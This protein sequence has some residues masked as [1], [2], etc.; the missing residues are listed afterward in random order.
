[1]RSRLMAGA[2]AL[3]S[4]VALLTGCGTTVGGTAVKAGSGWPSVGCSSRAQT[5]AV[6]SVLAAIRT[7]SV[8][9][10]MGGWVSQSRRP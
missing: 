2:V 5:S 4:A 1:M 10:A 9:M 6:T 7:V 8:V 3:V